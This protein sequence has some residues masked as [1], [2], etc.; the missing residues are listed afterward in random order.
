MVS[1]LADLV[2][3]IERLQR[4]ADAIRKSDASAAREQVRQLVQLYGFS[5]ADIF[6]TE[7]VTGDG[8]RLNQAGR[9]VRGGAPKYQSDDGRTWSGVGKRPAWFI[10]AL[11][12]GKSREDLLIDRSRIWAG[13]RPKRGN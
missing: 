9:P 13:N 4:E 7:S 2:Q 1:K 12:Q 8:V 10:E 3:E 6:G 5:S 11:A